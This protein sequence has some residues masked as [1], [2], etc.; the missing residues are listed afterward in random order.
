L[1]SADSSQLIDTTVTNLYEEYLFEDVKPGTYIIKTEKLN[2][3][4][5]AKSSEIVVTAGIDTQLN[6]LRLVFGDLDG[7]GDI[8]L[9]DLIRIAK[10]YGM[11]Q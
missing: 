5:S 11:V 10:N 4:L 9:F 8:G 2:N 3:Y 1:Y 6:T 7:D